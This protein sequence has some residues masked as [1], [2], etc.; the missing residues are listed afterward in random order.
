MGF[1]VNS[2]DLQQILITLIE[3]KYFW[4]TVAGGIWAFTKRH[5]HKTII[6]E[7][8]GYKFKASGMSQ[9]DLEKS[10]EGA[11]RLVVTQRERN[12]RDLQ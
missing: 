7:K 4:G 6:I 8:D 9:Q 5:N 12:E 1:I 11:Q 2:S 3:S 10:L